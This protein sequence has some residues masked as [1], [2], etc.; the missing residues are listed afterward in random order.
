[1]IEPDRHARIG[2]LLVAALERPAGDRGQYL[3]DICRGDESL[4]REVEALL[5]AHDAAGDFLE[6][7]I[8]LDAGPKAVQIEVRKEIESRSVGPYRLL[9]PIG[10][11]GMGIV[12][13]ASR[14]DRAFEKTVAIKLVKRG[15]DTEE[16]VRRFEKER[17][18]L[19]GL[20]HPNIARVLDG[21]TTDEGLPYLVMEYVDGLPIL[22][23][24]DARRLSTADRLRLFLEVCSA[25]QFAH[26]HLVVHRDLKPSNILVDA[27]SRPRL[28]EFGI[29]K[30]LAPDD[31]SGQTATGVRPMTPRYSSPEDR[32]SVV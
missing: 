30:I 11:G 1:M 5:D 16:I 20:D 14:S 28:L 10:H 26:R 4:R 12:Y 17:R 24:C 21:G 29:A 3:E 13:R 2:D 6:T 19:A 15:M 25:V 22:E 32:K 8:L 7:P 31:A 18:I 23:F 27:A 9:E